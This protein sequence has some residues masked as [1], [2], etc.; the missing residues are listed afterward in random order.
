MS[1]LTVPAFRRALLHEWSG[2]SKSTRAWS[3]IRGMAAC[4]PDSGFGSAPDD[5]HDHIPTSSCLSKLVIGFYY[6]MCC[7]H[8]SPTP[9]LVSSG[10]RQRRGTAARGDR[11]P[12]AVRIDASTHRRAGRC[13]S[14][15]G[16]CRSLGPP[17]LSG[18]VKAS[19]GGVRG[20]LA[21]YQRARSL[22]KVRAGRP[23]TNAVPTAA[24]RWVAPDG[25]R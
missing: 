15:Y 25:P 11:R 19:T 14:A 12:P 21:P 10:R 17:E 6:R 7:R 2:T 4:E 23:R 9:P 1:C 22:Q 3:S 20:P 16:G 24:H 5:L 18:R 8:G 13:A